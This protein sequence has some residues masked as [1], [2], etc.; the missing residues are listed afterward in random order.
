MCN[1]AFVVGYCD[2]R[3]L[4]GWYGFIDVLWC[5]LLVP[6]LIEQV[7]CTGEQVSWRGL[8]LELITVYT[9]SATHW[10]CSR[11]LLLKPHSRGRKNVLTKR[12]AGSRSVKRKSFFYPHKNTK[13][14][15]SSK[16][17]TVPMNIESLK[18]LIFYT[19][20]LRPKAQRRTKSPGQV[21]L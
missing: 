11:V 8:E 5:F 7:C 16:S 21:T 18:C 2:S 17:R 15:G 9:K 19:N 1:N 13:K 20:P 6:R 12:G 4:R 3:T 14:T 10:W